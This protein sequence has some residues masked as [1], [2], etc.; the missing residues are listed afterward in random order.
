MATLKSF[1]LVS[2][3]LAS[4]LTCSHDNCEAGDQTALLQ[5]HLTR[6]SELSLTSAGGAFF[7]KLGHLND[8][9]TRKSSLLEIQKSAV[10]LA[11]MD[12][13]EV[14]DL[15]VETVI[16]TANMLNETVLY[17]IITEDGADRMELLTAHA[18]FDPYIRTAEDLAADSATIAASQLAVTTA[19][20][21]LTECRAREF[22]SC[23]EETICVSTYIPCQT[24]E[25]CNNCEIEDS[26]CWLDNEI[27]RSWCVGDYSDSS[28]RLSTD[29]HGAAWRIETKTL[30]ERYSTAV[31][32]CTGH[33]T[34]C[35]THE[36]NCTSTLANYVATATE[37]ATTHNHWKQ[38]ECDHYNV[39]SSMVALDQQGFL[40]TL[41]AYN[42]IVARVMIEEADRKVEWEVLTRVICLLLTLA[43]PVDGET[44][45]TATQ[46]LIESCYAL[47][48]DVSHLN[49]EYLPAPDMV[50]LPEV[51]PLPCDAGNSPTYLAPEEPIY[52][53]PATCA[54]LYEEHIAPL[55]EHVCPCHQ[56][57]AIAMPA[58]ELDHYLMVNPSIS[59]VVQSGNEWT[60]VMPDGTT[61]IGAISAIHSGSM[62][63][64]TS[65]FFTDEE[66]ADTDTANGGANGGIASS[67]WAYGSGNA[68][69]SVGLGLEERFGQNGGMLYM[70]S[71]GTVIAA[72]ELVPASSAMGQDT[73]GYMSFQLAKEVDTALYDT[74]CPSQQQVTDVRH[75]YLGATHFC[76]T[77]NS[78]VAGAGWS[79]ADGCFVYKLANSN[80][81]FPLAQ[82]QQD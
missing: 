1:L 70:D 51:P 37:C 11:S 2:S 69:A 78:A 5:S 16:E 67:A 47:D 13:T 68:V 77:Q 27:H 44:S 63:T 54:A 58:F 74:A 46:A 31:D 20:T 3:G 57:A 55:D 15:L 23:E 81:A 41:E 71:A 12:R 75:L 72:R 38:K 8:P 4:G 48:V 17:A 35:S 19:A 66:I 73:S 49:I 36:E 82:A 39:I 30:F 18:A 40:F 34:D 21:Q 59:V 79:C 76:W 9:H 10:K 33:C 43:N 32:D 50:G 62:P 25:D 64:L 6:K 45:S 26:L 53:P 61:H 28:M 7:P 42:D 22:G 52:S 29:D 60:S 56:L 80:L 65:A 14:T 24:C